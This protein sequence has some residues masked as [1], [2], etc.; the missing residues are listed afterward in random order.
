VCDFA[1][2]IGFSY[3]QTNSMDPNSIRQ[4]ALYCNNSAFGSG[5]DVEDIPIDGTMYTR[6]AWHATRDVNSYLQQKRGNIL[7]DVLKKLSTQ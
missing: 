4:S 5:N 1:N 6:M 2:N 7:A 3:N